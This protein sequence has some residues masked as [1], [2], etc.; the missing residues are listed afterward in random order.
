[1]EH[2]AHAALRLRAQN[3]GQTL[4]ESFQRL[5]ASLPDPSWRSQE[6]ATQLGQS[7]VTTGRL[8]RAMGNTDPLAVLIQAPGPQPL[9]RV[10]RAAEGRGAPPAEVAAAQEAVDEF[11]D[12]I[13]D[14]IGGRRAL[15]S[16]LSSWVPEASREFEMRRRQSLF[17][18]ISELLGA[19][20]DLELVSAVLTPSAQGL[21]LDLAVVMGSLGVMRLRPGVQ[22][23][24]SASDMEAKGEERSV[25]LRHPNAGGPFGP[26]G[27]DR[28]C[29]NPVASLRAHRLGGRVRYTLADD[30]FGPDTKVDHLIAR[31]VP[32]DHPRA[33]GQP[34]GSGDIRSPFLLNIQDFPKHKLI[35]DCFVHRDLVCDREPQ[36]KLYG[37]AGKDP[38]NPRDDASALD[39][40]ETREGVQ[41][42]GDGLRHAA[43]GEFPNYLPMLTELFAHIDCNPDDYRLARISIDYPQYGSQVTLVHP[44]RGDGGD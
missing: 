21:P 35:M 3:T 11:R 37:V 14:H 2:G 10:I 19:Q 29:G 5:I 41:T 9:R 32:H 4:A 33:M 31:F 27:L 15:S 42:I 18:S 22:V 17:R 1:M 16:I 43:I 44:V 30:V 39:E 24:V 13:Q 34:S 7:V 23:D 26:G 8:L 40:L 12:L 25:D 38:V 28:F 6:L 20:Q 36:L